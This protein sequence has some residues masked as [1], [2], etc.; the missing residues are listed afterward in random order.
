[1]AVDTSTATPSGL[2]VYPPVLA[3][4][5]AFPGTAING[6]SKIADVVCAG[7][8]ANITFSSIPATYTDLLIVFQG[9]DTNA[10]ITEGSVRLKINGD[11]TAANYTTSQY[12]G[13][14]GA[15]ANI[16]TVAASVD[17]GCWGGI[18]GTSGNA[19]AQGIAEIWIPN[20][21]S[22]TLQKMV[23]SDYDDYYGAGP[24]LDASHITFVW[25]STA[26]I[27]SIVLKPSSG[28]AAGTRAVLYGLGGTTGGG[29][30]SV[31]TP[32]SVIF[33]GATGTL[34]E[35]NPNFFWDDTNNR[36]GIGTNA[37][38]NTVH[39]KNATQ[40]I[41][42]AESTSTAAGITTDGAVFVCVNTAG[43]TGHLCNHTT[44]YTANSIFKPS[45]L[46]LES[47]QAGGITI[48]NWGTSA[49]TVFGCAN[50]TGTQREAFRIKNTGITVFAAGTTAAGTAPL[51]LTSGPLNTTA[52][53]GAHEFLT[54]K[55][56]GTITT[57]NARK[58]FTLN[59]AALTAA[60]IPYTTTNGRLATESFLQY[61]ATNHK[62]NVSFGGPVG[63]IGLAKNVNAPISI[64]V[65]NY[66]AGTLANA[67]VYAGD[68]TT[69][70][71]CGM[72]KYSSGWTTVGAFQAND[73]LFYTETGRLLVA[74][75]GANPILFLTGGSA[76]ANERMQIDAT[77]QV[78]IGV[79]PA[80]FV[81][82]KA[83]TA[84][85]AF[86]VDDA[87]DTT[88]VAGLL[89]RTN[90]VANFHVTG[91]GSAWVP[92]FTLGATSQGVCDAL[93]AGGM[94][95]MAS[96]AAGVIKLATGG[97]AAANERLRIDAA[98]NVA[99]GTAALATTATDGFLYIPT[100][101]G[102]PTGVPTTFTGRV[103]IIYDSTNNFLYIRAGGTWKKSTV[104]T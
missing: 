13:G 42:E 50:G 4:A 18:P 39:I 82:I 23:R 70:K 100:C 95:L 27:N 80:T 61:D 16:G 78:G 81:H 56:Y 17:G 71:Y 101:A 60:L 25:K 96:N 7:G 55:F 77:G 99:L 49:E 79:T 73:G 1:M 34:S 20:Y 8:E 14:I 76:A 43:E 62:L 84:V 40:A 2:D 69:V 48:N 31:F 47:Y 97:N 83:P 88:L 57:S 9:R 66:T 87:A 94:L 30:S 36:L 5:G 65:S 53:A 68:G 104:Y 72:I 93:G 12:A 24:S 44:L 37:P 22:T 3:S 75:V 90:N 85:N 33:A 64:V 58:E 6:L 91:T 98:G 102:P 41:F 21:A 35:D 46:C 86:I 92:T 28:W 10:A 51:K 103:P 52:E 11:A 63:D 59:D 32:G 74:N 89:L 29:S 38:V 45:Q 26:A 15:A 67:G 19:N 54:D